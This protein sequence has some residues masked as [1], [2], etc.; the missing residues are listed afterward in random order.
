MMAGLIKV[1]NQLILKRPQLDVLRPNQEH[2]LI[3]E[4]L[5]QE[6][7]RANAG[8]K[9]FLPYLRAFGNKDVAIFSD[10]CTFPL[11]GGAM[12]FNPRCV[13]MMDLL[14]ATDIVAGSIVPCVPARGSSPE[15]NPQVKAGADKV[16][17]WLA[18]DGIGLKK[19]VFMIRLG[20]AGTIE[21]GLV[22]LKAKEP[23]Q[24]ITVVPIF[25]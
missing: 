11:I 6:L 20:A 23:P 10:W 14:S 19:A 7:R 4:V 22:E 25:R 3:S 16:L 13:E 24:H 5:Q 8:G 9:L 17:R 2:P 12:P 18:R 1:A 15:G 21:H